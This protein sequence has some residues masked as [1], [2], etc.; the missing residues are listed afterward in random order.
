MDQFILLNGA[1]V[2]IEPTKTTF[3]L[4]LKSVTGSTSLDPSDFGYLHVGP[5]QVVTVQ[6]TTFSVPFH[7]HVYDK[8][9]LELPSSSLLL[10]T[11][12]SVNGT[13][14][15]VQDLRIAGGSLTYH[16]VP[17]N[18]VSVPHPEVHIGFNSLTVKSGAEIT[19]LGDSKYV[20]TTRNFTL[21]SLGKFT[22]KN[23]TVSTSWFQIEEGGHLKL[24]SQS[25]VHSGPGMV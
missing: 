21:E 5:S 12:N 10:N 20:I 23:I 19:F 13:L 1:H 3:K 18:L 15:R 9:E 4:I 22:G 2:A 7:F 6:Q 16:N 11:H 24:D 25:N 17:Q 14:R 8:G